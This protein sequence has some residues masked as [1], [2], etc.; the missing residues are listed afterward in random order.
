MIVQ[1]RY[2][3]KNRR[4]QVDNKSTRISKWSKKMQNR[5]LWYDIGMFWVLF[6]SRMA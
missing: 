2:G 6:G 5:Q 1:D 3:P 4:N